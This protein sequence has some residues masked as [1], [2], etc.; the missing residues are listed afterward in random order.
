MPH[1]SSRAV[2]ILDIGSTKALNGDVDMDPLNDPR[3]QDEFLISQYLD[4]DLDEGSARELEARFETDT[5]L[6]ALLDRMRA[7]DALVSEWALPVPELDWDRFTQE[8]TDRRERF[9]WQHRRRRLQLFVPLAAA[10]V[11]ILAVTLFWKGSPDKPQAEPVLVV[12]YERAD[13]WRESPELGERIAVVRYDR[14]PP[15]QSLVQRSG[16]KVVIGIAGTGV[17]SLH[18][19]SAPDPYF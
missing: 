5:E 19:D 11:L 16:P 6:A 12:H 9:A 7:T 2:A 15:L 4:G 18:P 14:S 17:G 10:A 8:A 1:F 3:L 13:E